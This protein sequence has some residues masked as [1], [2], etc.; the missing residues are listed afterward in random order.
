MKNNKKIIFL[1][2]L[3]S[4]IQLIAVG[5]NKQQI[6]L[7]NAYDSDVAVNL[8][9][10]SA[11]YPYFNSYQDAILKRDARDVMIKAPYSQYHLVSIDVAPVAHDAINW[12][13]AGVYGSALTVST[14]LALVVGGAAHL[15]VGGLT[16]GSQSGAVGFTVG[17]LVAGL[18]FATTSL[19]LGG[20]SVMMSKLGYGINHAVNSKKLETF[21]NSY[22]LIDA[23]KVQ[24]GLLNAIN[25]RAYSEFDTYKSL[26]DTAFKQLEEKRIEYSQQE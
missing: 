25:V 24:T 4:C 22:F 5:K 23:K 17:A 9:W 21:N 16:Q 7:S 1:S 11:N 19:A 12:A 6:I 3:L 18:T 15:F 13:S 14:A 10:K 8:T 2:I 20:A 26:V